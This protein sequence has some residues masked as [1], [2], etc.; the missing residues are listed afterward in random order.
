MTQV[1]E[2]GEIDRPTGFR[3]Q[4]ALHQQNRRAWWNAQAR[5]GVWVGEPLGG[6]ETPGPGRFTPGQLIEE[7][8]EIKTVER[9]LAGSNNRPMSSGR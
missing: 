6:I 1:V 2:L 7:L 3:Q 5:R 8:H 4:L 9:T